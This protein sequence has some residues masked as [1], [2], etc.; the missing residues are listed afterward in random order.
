MN[1]PLTPPQIAKHLGVKVDRVRGW[2]ARG[3]LR[4]FNVADGTRPLWRIELAALEAFILKRSTKL[5]APKSVRHLPVLR[6]YY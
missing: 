5:L 3:E 4:A 2:I 1:K 6:T